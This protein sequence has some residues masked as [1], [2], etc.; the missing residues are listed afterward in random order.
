MV[1]RTAVRGRV[2]AFPIE[3]HEALTSDT[4]LELEFRNE[5]V[6]DRVT[7]GTTAVD[8]GV[9]DDAE[10]GIMISIERTVPGV[11]GS[12]L[13]FGTV[14]G[15]SEAQFTDAISELPAIDEVALLAEGE[16]GEE[17][18]FELTVSEP[19]ASEALRMAHRKL[20]ASF[21]EDD[22]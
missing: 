15:M 21:Y 20:L 13:Q 4:V 11:D 5:G 10:P 22:R 7:G 6:A 12:M 14:S 19:S 1:I 3:Q 18:P 9:G 17:L 16:T 2:S 8:G